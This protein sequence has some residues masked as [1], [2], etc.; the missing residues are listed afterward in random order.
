MRSIY[1][2]HRSYPAVGPCGTHGVDSQ[3]E[4]LQPQLRALMGHPN[5]YTFLNSLSSC[6][7]N[8]LSLAYFS[9]LL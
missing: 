9:I 6:S 1:S 3:K 7:L 2:N 4:L 5:S 8:I